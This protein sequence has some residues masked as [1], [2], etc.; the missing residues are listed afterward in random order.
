MPAALAPDNIDDMIKIK[1]CKYL[2]DDFILCRWDLIP[3][4]D[5]M[6]YELLQFCLTGKVHD[7][8]YNA[9]TI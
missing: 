8:V 4:L 3:K 5:D 7:Q 6:F 2:N 9:P 1:N